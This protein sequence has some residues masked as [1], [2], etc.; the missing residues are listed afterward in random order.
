MKY[1]NTKS[2]QGRSFKFMLSLKRLFELRF[3][4]NETQIKFYESKLF[5][6]V[7]RS[8]FL[9]NYFPTRLEKTTTIRCI[10]VRETGVPW[11]HGGLIDAPPENSCTS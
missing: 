5:L 7:T 8:D 9:G 11:H 3:F 6:R 1:T 2:K 4:L 10:A